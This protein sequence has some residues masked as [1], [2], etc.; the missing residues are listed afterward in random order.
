MKW[1]GRFAVLAVSGLALGALLTGPA[2]AAS[3]GLARTDAGTLA[4]IDCG[5][6]HTAGS[7]LE[8]SCY[9]PDS[10]PGSVDVTYVCSTPLDGRQVVFTEPGNPIGAGAALRLSRDCGPGQVVLTYQVWPLTASQL[11]DQAARQERI[12][13]Q[14]DQEEGR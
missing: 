6:T 10:E 8:I 5:A 11:G 14:R 7:R 4:E 1:G 2:S 13:R 12:R 3:G 9:N